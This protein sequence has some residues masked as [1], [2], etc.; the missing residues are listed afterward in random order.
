MHELEDVVVGIDVAKATLDV[1]VRPSG[2]ERHLANDAAGIA[3]AVAWRQTVGA[4]V[5]VIE[6]TGGYEAPLVAALA[7]TVP[8]AVVNP[9]QVRDFAR[10][11]GRLA[12]TDRLDAP[13]LAPFGEAVRPTPRPLADEAAPA[14]P[15]WSSVGV[16]SWRCAP[17][18]RTAWGRRV[19]AVRARIQRIL[20]GSR[21]TWETST[22]TC[23]S[24]ARQLALA[25]AGRPAAERPGH[26]SDRLP[27]LAGGR[28]RAGTALPRADRGPGR[29]RTAESRQ[30]D[31]ARPS[32]RL[33][34]SGAVRTT[35]YRGTLRARAA[36]PSSR[37]S[38]T[39][40]SRR[41]KPRRWR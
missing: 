24:G 16:R 6:A 3:E 31:V 39:A 7:S 12:K 26:R 37:R 33:G 10:A 15:R 2:E 17:P 23:A 36:I 1:A 13:V 35:L 5:I 34:R 21:R 27:D 4:R 29:G 11:T 25:R 40:S 20:P 9:R 38:T 19:A 18:R 32:D 30:R 14:E 22:P 41:A 8:V 28:T